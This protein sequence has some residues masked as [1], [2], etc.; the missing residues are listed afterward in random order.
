MAYFGAVLIALAS[1]MLLNVQ[2]A[3]NRRLGD[4]LVKPLSAASVSFIVGLCALLICM[5]CYRTPLSV[6]GAAKAPWWAWIGGFMGAFYVAASI[7]LLPRLGV[8]ALIGL[9]IAG[10][11]LSALAF[12]HWGLMG[13]P[14]HAMNVPR[15][16]GAALLSIGIGLI[17]RY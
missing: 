17:L 10:Q 5:A 15:L 4:A 2:V 13:V 16:V 9:C 7:V 3:A 8:T 1:G 11:L 12:D 14:I 6:S